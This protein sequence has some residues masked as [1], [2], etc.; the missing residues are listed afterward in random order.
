M[1]SC[2]RSHHSKM[3]RCPECSRLE[4]DEALKFCDFW[5]FL[6]KTDPLYDSLRGDQRF[7]ELVKRFNP[8][9]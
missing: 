6:I 5:L 7:Q 3:K 1:K 2:V 9:V 4:T 8:P